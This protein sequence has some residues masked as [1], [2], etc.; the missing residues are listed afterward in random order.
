MHGQ[1]PLEGELRRAPAPEPAPRGTLAWKWGQFLT[2]EELHD[3]LPKKS[4]RD[5]IGLEKAKESAS[6]K[7][8]AK[9]DAGLEVEAVLTG[10][11]VRK[12]DFFTFCFDLVRIPIL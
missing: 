5:T 6:Y 2:V 4:T 1:T 11:V 9:S 12:R 10:R 7:A 8:S 3:Q